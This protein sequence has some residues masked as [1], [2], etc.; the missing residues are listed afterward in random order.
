MTTRTTRHAA[1]RSIT[2]QAR[3]KPLAMLIALAFAGTAAHGQAAA[4][5]DAASAAEAG[6]LQTVTV[7]AE[8]ITEDVKSVP[9][10][11]STIGGEALDVLN[12]GGDDVRAL[13]GR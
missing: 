8:R 13:S 2:P 12:S 7:T 4:P 9:I 5:A 6:K 3:V 11:V 1:A 10:S